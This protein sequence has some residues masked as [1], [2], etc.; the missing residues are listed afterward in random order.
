MDG[1]TFDMLVDEAT[2][3]VSEV[4]VSREADYAVGGDRLHNFNEAANIRQI[5]PVAACLG[6]QL[7]HTVS[8]EDLKRDMLAGR[9]ISKAR[10][11]EKCIDEFNYNL[12]ALACAIDQGI[13]TEP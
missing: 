6:M 7:K 5:T 4:L 2:K 3:R 12:L 1:K 8:M 9:N 11:M 10:F 13:V